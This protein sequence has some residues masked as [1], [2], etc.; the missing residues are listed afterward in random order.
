MYQ[1]CMKSSIQTQEVESYVPKR[2]AYRN[3]LRLEMPR[4]FF[5]TCNAPEKKKLRTPRTRSTNRRGD[6]TT[7]APTVLA[8]SITELAASFTA[9][10]TGSRGTK[11]R[12]TQHPWLKRATGSC[13]SSAANVY[14][15]HLGDRVVRTRERDIGNPRHKLDVQEEASDR[16]ASL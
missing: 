4:M 15:N 16:F 5:L 7:A 12:F 13:R 11:S 10:V 14:L 3:T 6:P 1:P 8:V 2:S 9:C